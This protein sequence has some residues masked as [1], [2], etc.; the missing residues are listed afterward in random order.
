MYDGCISIRDVCSDRRF[1]I[2]FSITLFFCIIGAASSSYSPGLI[3]WI[4]SMVFLLITVCKGVETYEGQ[5]WKVVLINVL[6]A[7]VL[8]LSVVWNEDTVSLTSTV[9]S[10]L[11]IFCGVALASLT[12]HVT[13]MGIL[14]TTFWFFL[15]VYNV[16]SV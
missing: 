16:T 2:Y 11:V 7:V 6:Y 4:F 5:L 13:I 9:C 1:W 14:F 8:V 12:Y 10:L 3:A 15:T